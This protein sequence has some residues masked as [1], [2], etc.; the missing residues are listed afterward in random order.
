MS[1]GCLGMFPYDSDVSIMLYPTSVFVRLL[2][3]A[4]A[5]RTVQ[6]YTYRDETASIPHGHL[7]LGPAL[8]VLTHI[9][10]FFSSS[11]LSSSVISTQALSTCFAQLQLVLPP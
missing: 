3:L 11:N 9:L 10:V 1:W 4:L 7:P 8:S 5:E 6:V 2:L